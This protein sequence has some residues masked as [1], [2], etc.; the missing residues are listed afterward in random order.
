[1]KKVILSLHQSSPFATPILRV[2]L[3]KAPKGALTPSAVPRVRPGGMTGATAAQR[4]FGVRRGRPPSFHSYM[5]RP[6][7]LISWIASIFLLIVSF[8]SLIGNE[9][10]NGLLWL[11]IALMF[12]PPVVQRL[13]VYLHRYA[14]YGIAA[15]LFVIIAINLPTAPTVQKQPQDE[16]KVSSGTSAAPEVKNDP[17]PSVK[18]L[19][20]I[21]EISVEIFDAQGRMGSKAQPPIEIIVQSSASDC[22]DSKAK[23]FDVMKA[24]Y[25]D[26]SLKSSVGRVVFVS[27][28][29]LR[30][31]LGADA[32][33]RLSEAQ[34]SNSG[35]T[36]FYKVLKQMHD[37]DGDP[38]WQTWVQTLRDCN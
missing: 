21:K 11:G 3:G 36:N 12:L 7:V 20:G 33:Y 10:L 31:S 19:S 28:P 17:A 15:G 35:P 8:G 23:L 13:G 22:F 5:P 37:G 30:A 34:W 38:Y 2:A 9:R 32:G 16:P 14:R 27:P 6:S 4:P 25:T 26:Q 18:A 24:V 29:F 1:M